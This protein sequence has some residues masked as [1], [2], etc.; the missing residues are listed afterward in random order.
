MF[1]IF[2]I[3]ASFSIINIINYK[4]SMNEKKKLCKFKEKCPLWLQKQDCG[5]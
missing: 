2:I 4:S 1:R 5:F 3:L